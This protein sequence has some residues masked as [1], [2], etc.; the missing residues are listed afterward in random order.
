MNDEKNSHQEIMQRFLEMSKLMVSVTERGQMLMASDIK[1]KQIRNWFFF[2]AFIAIPLLYLLLGYQKFNSLTPDK[3]DGP[4]VAVVR[5]DGPISASEDANALRINEAVTKAFSDEDA[6]GIVILIN[7]GG[8][9]PVQAASIH[10]W[11]MRMR[12]EKPDVK[13]AVVG[14]DMMTSAAYMIATGVDDI[15]VNRSTITGSIGVIMSSYGF[16]DLIDKLGV[17]RRVYTA[18]VHKNRLDSFMPATKENKEKFKT[19]LSNLHQHFIDLVKETREDKL[20]GDESLLFSGDFWTGEEAL[21]LG[22][23]D[24]LMDFRTV[25]KE[26]FGAEQFVDYTASQSFVSSLVRR[27]KTEMKTLLTSEEFSFSL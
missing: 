7:S 26:K 4:Y 9:S 1:S 12:K 16:V 13:V 8:G 17:E 25:M 3:T 14:Q 23:V 11:I 22:L 15:Y 5:I 18:G 2:G 19:I 20:K 10:D 21:Q 27:F 24:G 6:S